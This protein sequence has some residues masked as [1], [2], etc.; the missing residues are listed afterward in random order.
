MLSKLIYI[1]RNPGRFMKAIR[2]GGD[3]N[4]HRYIRVAPHAQNA[5]DIF[6]GQWWS[7]LPDEYGVGAGKV[8][9]YWDPRI[10]FAIRAF[11]GVE[12]KAVLEL[13]PL[14]GGHTFMLERAGARS[15][16]AVEGDSHS[17]LRCLIAK[18][19]VDLKRARFVFGDLEEYLRCLPDYLPRSFDATIA[20]GVLYHLRRPVEVIHW[21]ARVCTQVYVWTHYYD[22]ERLMGNEHMAHRFRYSE[23]GEFEGFRYMSHRYEYGD[24]LRTARFAGGNAETSNWLSRDDLLGALRHAGFTQIEIGEDDPGHLNG[25]AISLVASKPGSAPAASVTGQPA[26]ETAR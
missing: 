8:P 9:L 18:E 15:I 19:I 20:S 1:A 11:G 6:K 24:F 12:G 13:G 25:P 4:V 3:A 7:Q 23:P 2:A 21:I 10:T 5:V 14:E 26:P 22:R 16:F 17:Y